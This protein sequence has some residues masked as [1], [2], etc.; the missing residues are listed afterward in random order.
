MGE[1]I[2]YG[3]CPWCKKTDKALHFVMGSYDHGKSIWAGWVCMDCIQEAKDKEWYSNIFSRKE[4]NVYED[5][6]D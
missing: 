6:D 5:R 4:V 3:I 1:D 2:R